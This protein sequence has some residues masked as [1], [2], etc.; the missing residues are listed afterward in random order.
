MPRDFPPR[1]STLTHPLFFPQ[2]IISRDPHIMYGDG[3]SH[4]KD[5]YLYLVLDT[6]DPSSS[7]AESTLRCGPGHFRGLE[8]PAS[9]HND[10]RTGVSGPVVMGWKI[11]GSGK[12]GKTGDSEDDGGASGEKLAWRE[13]DNE[14]EVSED[15]KAKRSATDEYDLLRGDFVG[16]TYSV[17]I[18]S[19]LNWTKE[20]VLSC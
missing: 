10:K 9:T 12:A 20:G 1:T 16:E 19:G 2:S 4:E 17:P 14:D 13:W 18:R 6:P 7:C 5:S 15:V 3:G 8:C 11:S